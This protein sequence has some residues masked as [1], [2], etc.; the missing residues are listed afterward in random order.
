MKVKSFFNTVRHVLAG[1]FEEVSYYIILLVGLIIGFATES[2]IIGILSIIL[3][4]IPFFIF[5]DKII[6]PKQTKQEE[7]N[8][9]RKLYPSWLSLLFL[10]A[11][12][13]LGSLVAYFV[14]N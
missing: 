12:I 5:S 8:R 7:S 11:T 10:S 1:F 4:S 14:T 13:A 6:R 3:C 9:P 2:I